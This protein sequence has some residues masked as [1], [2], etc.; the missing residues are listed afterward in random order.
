LIAPSSVAKQSTVE[1]VENAAVVVNPRTIFKYGL[2]N[3]YGGGESVV[4][5]IIIV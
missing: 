5:D 4:L 2:D 1:S 3:A